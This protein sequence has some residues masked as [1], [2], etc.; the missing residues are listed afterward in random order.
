[1]HDGCAGGGNTGDE[2]LN[3]VR[4]M[5]FSGLPIPVPLRVRCGRCGE[6]FEMAYFEDACT[7]CGAVHAITPCH[8]DDAGSVRV[9]A[10]RR[11][12]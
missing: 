12:D 1:M 10:E 5:G 3:K 9:S 8:A 4:Q 7:A 2:V 11:G 6:T